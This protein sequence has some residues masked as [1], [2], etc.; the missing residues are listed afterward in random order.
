[1]FLKGKRMSIAV[2]NSFDPDVVE[3]LEEMLKKAKEGEFKQVT[4]VFVDKDKCLSYESSSGAANSTIHHALY[5]AMQ[6]YY[7]IECVGDNND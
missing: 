4:V 6:N 5:H 1:M 7:Q 3:L 2:I